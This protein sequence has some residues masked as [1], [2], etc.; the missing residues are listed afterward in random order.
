M[1]RTALCVARGALTLGWRRCRPEV[2]DCSVA[3]LEVHSAMLDLLG[4]LPATP[5][6][7]VNIHMGG[8]YGD[9]VASMERFAQVRCRRACAAEVMQAL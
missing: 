2:V 3:E 6:N 8:V 1:A 9:K 4:M 7:K 5:F